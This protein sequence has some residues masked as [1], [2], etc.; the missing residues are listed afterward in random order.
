MRK[1]WLLLI[2]LVFSINLNFMV[3]EAMAT[4][5]YYDDN[6]RMIKSVYEGGKI[7]EYF[8]DENGYLTERRTQNSDGSVFSRKVNLTFND[9][10]QIVKRRYGTT[11][12]YYIYTYNE[13][14]T[15]A[16]R[17]YYN[18]GEM[19]YRNEY[20]YDQNG[21]QS[22]YKKYDNNGAFTGKYTYQYDDYGN[23]VAVYRGTTLQS[24]NHY[25]DNWLS[26]QAQEQWLKKRK[27]IYT[28]EEATKLSKDTGNK[29]MLR[30]K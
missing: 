29:F 21:R 22:G 18:A 3:R 1:I 12:E 30:Y 20:Q 8:Y 28:V 17:T 4:D 14:G 13:D 25:T 16:T 10:G 19:S 24:S 23:I 7:H 27:L 15:E 2:G 9:L 5:C 11:Q 26:R 6:G